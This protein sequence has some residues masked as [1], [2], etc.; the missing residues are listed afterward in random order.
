[1]EGRKVDSHIVWRLPGSPIGLLG[2]YLL[3][4]NTRLFCCYSLCRKW[5]RIIESQFNIRACIACRA[6]G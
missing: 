2:A 3:A 1:M 6:S 4:V 5:S